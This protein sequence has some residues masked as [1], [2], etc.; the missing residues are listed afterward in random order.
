MNRPLRLIGTLALV[1]APVL[2]ALPAHATTPTPNPTASKPTAGKPTTSKPT[3][4]KP[5]YVYTPYTPPDYKAD[6][7]RAHADAKS[8][9]DNVAAKLGDPGIWVDSAVTKLSASEVAELDRAVKSAAAPMRIAVIP[10][11]AINTAPKGSY[12]TQLAWEGEEIASQLYDRVGVEGVYAVLV[13]ARSE[14]DGRGFNAVQH[15]DK[16]PTY[17]VGDAVDE[18]VD[19]CAPDY[20]GILTRF[21]QRAQVIDEPFFIDAAPYAGGAAGVAFLWWGGTTLSARRARRRDEKNHLEVSV[22][23]LNEEIIALSQQ[24][25]EL[26]TTSDP[27]QSKVSKDVLDTVEKARHRLDEAKGDEDTEA[28]ATLLG[29]ARYGMVCLEALRAGKPIPEPTPPCFFDP[30]H[31]PS[32]AAVEW[33]PEGGSAREV[34]VCTACAARAAAKQEPEIRMVMLRD[35]PRP[36]WTLGE[37]L[38]SYMDG[39]WSQGDGKRWWFPDQDARRAGEAMRSR[40]RSRRAGARLSSFSDSVGTAI[41]SRSSSSSYGSYDNDNDNDN[42]S[43]WS[44]GSSRR[45]SY[46]SRTRSSGGGSSRRS[47]RRSGGSRGF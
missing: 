7:E 21:V 44:S 35:R 4:S 39:Y 9:L 47:S 25:S 2:A 1:A 38:A 40:W 32:T 23:V 20:D 10:A 3:R 30:R 26:P 43:S 46:S 34:Q 22:P 12:R 13:D 11:S 17:H 42:R 16:G 15:A 28:V 36:Y 27:E 24:V 6:R 5:T 8:Y 31:G 29:S 33:A 14:S 37:E 45:R 41:S 19:C 18:A